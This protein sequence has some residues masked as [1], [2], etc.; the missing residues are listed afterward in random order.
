V[1]AKLVHE[2]VMAEMVRG[3]IP[4]QLLQVPPA[5]LHKVHVGSIRNNVHSQLRAKQELASEPAEKK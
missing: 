1:L 2:L 3:H 5:Y 4:D